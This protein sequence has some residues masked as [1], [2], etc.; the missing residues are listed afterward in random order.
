MLALASPLAPRPHRR[1]FERIR[2][3]PERSAVACLVR[4]DHF[5]VRWTGRRFSITA[6]ACVRDL[7]A[8]L[9][10]AVLD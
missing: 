1:G 5:I 3:F 2:S 9:E 10:S 4:D 8:A 6:A 7:N